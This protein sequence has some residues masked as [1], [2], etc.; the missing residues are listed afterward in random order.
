MSKCLKIQL[1]KICDA[2]Y[3]QTPE[4]INFYNS[5]SNYFLRDSNETLKF[6]ENDTKVFIVSHKNVEWDEVEN[7]REI[8]RIKSHLTNRFPCLIKR[9]SSI[10]DDI[11]EIFLLSLFYGDLSSNDKQ[12]QLQMLLV[13]GV[14]GTENDNQKIILVR[15]ENDGKNVSAV[16]FSA[17]KD[18]YLL[19]FH[20]SV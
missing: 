2:I 8:D 13:D 14:R 1:K 7:E 4:K 19:F 20:V 11:D 10:S 3:V 6:S 5:I 12:L 16:F 17:I 9:F 15:L 18:F